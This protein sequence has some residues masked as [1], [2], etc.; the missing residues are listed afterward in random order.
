MSNEQD[1]E[2]RG[3]R[4]LGDEHAIRKQV[5]IAKAHGVPIEEPH[6]YAK[7]HAL[8][9]GNPKC[10]LCANPRKLRKEKTLQEIRFAQTEKYDD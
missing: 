4:I 3:K 5:S 7:H 2:K 9:C 8:N 10:S 1:K 6:R